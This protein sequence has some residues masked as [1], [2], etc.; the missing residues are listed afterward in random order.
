MNTL[1]SF[2]H[3]FWRFGRFVLQYRHLPSSAILHPF[4]RVK[5][6]F[7]PEMCR[8][9]TYETHKNHHC[10]PR[11]SI[12]INQT[13]ITF[14]TLS[15]KLLYRFS[16]MKWIKNLS[17]TSFVTVKRNNMICFQIFQNDFRSAC[18]LNSFMMETVT[19]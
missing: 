7:A 18:S 16:S 13:D 4:T 12:K 8:P 1:V 17:K 6:T 9:R 15:H 5:W 14:L 2:S 11:L 10:V 3:L 19:I